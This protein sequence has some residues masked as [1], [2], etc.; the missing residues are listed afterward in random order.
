MTTINDISD[1]ALAKAS[2]ILD[3]TGHWDGAATSKASAEAVATLVQVGG[4]R[5]PEKVSAAIAADKA[6]H[7]TVK[8]AKEE[9]ADHKAK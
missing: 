9:K 5:Q 7:E 4:L 6:A 3:N 2:E 1:K 8:P